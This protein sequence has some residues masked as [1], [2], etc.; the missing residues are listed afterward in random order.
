MRRHRRI[1]GGTRRDPGQELVT[2]QES[3]RLDGKADVWSWWRAPLKR[4][5]WPVRWAT[6]ALFTLA[7]A[8][9]SILA[10][11]D[12]G[13]PFQAADVA[14]Y[15]RMA[16]GRMHAVQHPFAS[17]PRGPLAA[18]GLANAMHVRMETGFEALGV[19]SLL[20]LLAVV[21]ALAVDA[22]APRWIAFAMAAVAFW[23]ELW[24]GYP[25]PDLPYAAL[26]AAFLLLLRA[27]WYTAAAAWLLPLTLAR[28][29]T[30]LV[31]V[32]VLGVGWRQLRPWRC[33]LA[34]AAAGAG[35]IAVR[36]LAAG[37]AGNQEHLPAALY[38]A[39]KVPWNL[40]R[41]LGVM[42]W[43]NLYPFLCATPAWRMEV[44]LGSIRE[45]GV[46]RLS[47]L[48]PTWVA[49]AF[50]TTFGLLPLALAFTLR[51]GRGG[52]KEAWA[53]LGVMPRFCLVYGAVSFGLA[54]ALGTAYARLF[55]YGWPLFLVALPA[56]L[57][58]A[59]T[60]DAADR[61]RTSKGIGSFWPVVLLVPAHLLLLYLA[62]HFWGAS[63]VWV[64]A[65]VWGLAAAVCGAYFRTSRRAVRRSLPARN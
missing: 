37:A 52:V 19:A 55:G 42:P 56:M 2:A 48:T 50:F 20:F 5:P 11:K 21:F 22:G 47:L 44:N 4:S 34:L 62:F 40:V 41:A 26:V 31:L 51:G 13:D 38:L 54:V 27:R 46:C 30:L 10:E 12:A 23:P 9:G 18:R 58:A 28:E 1:N 14:Y 33:G 64:E 32:C 6:V 29:S 49:M 63:N 43:S 17:R 57:G 25:L 7:T 59:P 61:I 35:T 15:L 3:A 24:Q 60:V 16:H 8:L 45:V 53:R 36:Q 39:G 65:G